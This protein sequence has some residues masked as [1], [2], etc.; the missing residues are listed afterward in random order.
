MDPQHN[1][2]QRS[3]STTALFDFAQDRR[4]F[5]GTAINL[6]AAPAL[7]QVL[8]TGFAGRALAQAPA[9]TEDGGRCMQAPQAHHVVQDDAAGQS[10]HDVRLMVL[11][12]LEEE[13]D[14][15]DFGDGGRY[16]DEPDLEQHQDIEHDAVGDAQSRR[17]YQQRGV[18]DL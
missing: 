5:L 14:V 4:Q 7:A 15:E 17:C 3:P 9:P 8:A 6:A 12:A 18:R 16:N 10:G 11:L 13:G 2:P 1:R